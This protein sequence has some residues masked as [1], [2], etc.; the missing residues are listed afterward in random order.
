[1]FARLPWPCK[2]EGSASIVTLTSWT[3]RNREG[4]KKNRITDVKALQCPSGHHAGHLVLH[5]HWRLEN[6]FKCA[7]SLLPIE[8]W[9]SEPI[10]K[11]IGARHGESLH[12]WFIYCK[13]SE[14]LGRQLLNFLL[15]PTCPSMLGWCWDFVVRTLEFMH[16]EQTM[17]VSQH[18]YRTELK[19]LEQEQICWAVC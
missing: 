2:G 15:F 5:S 7:G 9:S 12:S 10:V 1:M 19:V 18:W 17:L 4:R 13:L 3:T 6:A 16:Y 8:D 14:I 11:L